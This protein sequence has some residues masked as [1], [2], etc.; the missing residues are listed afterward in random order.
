MIVVLNWYSPS[1]VS[2]FGVLDVPSPPKNPGLASGGVWTRDDELDGLRVEIGAEIDG[3]RF[4]RLNG[5][6]SSESLSPVEPPF[7]KKRKKN[8]KMKLIEAHC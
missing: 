2:L 6:P 4:T 3:R 7:Q 1:G 5:L 8:T